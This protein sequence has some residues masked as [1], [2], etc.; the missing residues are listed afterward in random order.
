MVNK[1]LLIKNLL[2][3]YDENTFFDKK[4]QLNLDTKSGKAKFLKHICALSNSNPFN[5]SYL[6]IGVED[7]DNTIGG[8]DFFDDSK[9]QNLVDAYLLNPPQITYENVLFT[10]LP[11]GRV[12]GLVTIRG[13]QGISRFKKTI[14][15]IGKDSV[16]Y[17][18]G[19]NS[20][21]DIVPPAIG[22]NKATVESIEN[23]SKNNLD[24]LLESVLGF[25]TETH[26]DL[27][28]RYQVFK[29]NFI[30]CWAGFKTKI[31]GRS[32]YSRVD[33][34]L[35]NEQIRLFYSSLDAVTIYFNEDK[36]VVTE[37][38]KLGLNDK[39]SFY[40]FEEVVFRFQDNGSYEMKSKVLFE[41][42]Q[43]NHNMLHYIY[44]ANVRLLEKLRTAQSLNEL[45]LN[46]MKRL[47]HMLMICY[48]NG[49]TEAK[50]QLYDLGDL[51]KSLEV[52]K[53][54]KSY[55]E[56]MRIL[57]KLKYELEGNG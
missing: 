7:D 22:S 9:I 57:R 28:P 48:L 3:Y 21:P 51:L 36:F 30:I 40:A 38:V 20:V 29:E 2:S 8:V 45:D 44:E 53:I 24:T 52:P 14:Y 10:S 18:V 1:R 23:M 6:I 17:R 31:R 15:T 25:M 4:R 19:S 16:F 46:K 54:Y 5:N 34:E 33:I 26:K 42:P 12:V 35:I 41:P 32:F 47:P 13:K 39:T 11:T 37:Y 27:N 55:K 49:F 43:Y 50:S 56:V